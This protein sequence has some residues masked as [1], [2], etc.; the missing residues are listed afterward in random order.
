MITLTS[1]GLREDSKIML[2]KR[3]NSKAQFLILKISSKLSLLVELTLSPSFNR[4]DLNHTN[5]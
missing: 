4:Q 2:T 1:A 3:S 5:L